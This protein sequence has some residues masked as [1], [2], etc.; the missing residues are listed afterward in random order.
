VIRLR[1]FGVRYPGFELGPITVHLAR[2]ERVALVG[3]NGAGKSTT[4]RVLGGLL[5]E[6]RGMAQIE[7]VEVHAASPEVR[8]RVGI[9]PDRLMGFGWMTVSE[10]LAFLGAFYRTWDAA[11]AQHLRERLA[12]PSSTKVAQL[13]RG[14]QVKLSLV[15]AEAFRPPLLL[16]DEPTSGIDPIMRGEI[17]DIIDGLVPPGGGR[18]LVY[19]SHILEDLD[20]IVSR[21][22]LLKEGRLVEDVSIQRLVEDGG[23]ASP[24]EKVYRKLADA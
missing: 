7:G 11:Y 19:S 5:R 12:L 6:Y 10:H 17:L 22:L 15:S 8:E 9:L 3:A 24:A 18:T 20:R 23:G 21:V 14:M 4:L 1:D 2:G 16:L 13:S